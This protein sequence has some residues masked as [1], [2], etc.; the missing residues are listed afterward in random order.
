M[1][2]Y[3]DLLSDFLSTPHIYLLHVH[4]SMLVHCQLNMC[5]GCKLRNL[6]EKRLLLTHFRP[7]KAIQSE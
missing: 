5:L 4:S 7:T 2:A 6:L 3:F 1:N